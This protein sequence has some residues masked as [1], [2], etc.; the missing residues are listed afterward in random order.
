MQKCVGPTFAG[1]GGSPWPAGNYVPRLRLQDQAAEMATMV[2]Q[3]WKVRRFQTSSLR[4]QDKSCGD[5][6]EG[7]TALEGTEV[8]D[9]PL[10]RRRLTLQLGERRVRGPGE[11]PGRLAWIYIESTTNF[12]GDFDGMVARLNPYLQGLDWATWSDPT[13]DLT[14]ATARAARG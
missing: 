6:D 11:A 9:V 2:L 8:P 1:R 14:A 10:S 4:L 7:A 12:S 13:T 3:L 5:G